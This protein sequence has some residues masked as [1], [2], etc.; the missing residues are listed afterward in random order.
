MR[1]PAPSPRS[2]VRRL[3]GRSRY[4]RDTVDGILDAGLVGH[5][6][7][8]A[9]DHP[10]A[11]PMLYVRSGEV[12]YLHGSRL[13]RLLKSASGGTSVCFTVTLLDG[14]VLARSAFHHSVN[15]R[16]VAIL[17]RA[18]PVREEAEKRA[19]LDALVEHVAAGRT[20]DARRPD[21][22]ELAATE[23]IALGLE[24]ASTKIRTGGPVDAPED[25]KLPVWAGEIPLGLRAG[26][27]V[28]DP[29]CTVAAPDYVTRLLD[30]DV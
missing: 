30:A 18:R 2:K 13:S 15:Y 14:L 24:E 12:V 6:A 25:Y 16:S 4:D 9:N 17:G 26:T 8:I 7:F 19:A 21:A 11:I 29:R 10:Y 5:L 1:T 27:P 20:R 3:A 22:K 23:V 28:T